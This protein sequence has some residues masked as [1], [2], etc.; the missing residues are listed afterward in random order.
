MKKLILGA[1]GSIGSALA[2]KIVNDGGQVHLVGRDESSLS[3]LASELDSTFTPCDVLEEN[4]SEKN[5]LETEYSIFL[6]IKPNCFLFFNA[7]LPT[8]LIKLQ[9]KSQLRC[10]IK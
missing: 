4:F 10:K 2:K 9:T 3:A 8:F 1:T 6:P 7:Y 5:F